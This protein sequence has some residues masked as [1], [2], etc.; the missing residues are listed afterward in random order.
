MKVIEGENNTHQSNTQSFLFIYI[1]LFFCSPPNIFKFNEHLI[2]KLSKCDFWN[3]IDMIMKIHEIWSYCRM[4]RTN[5]LNLWYS[6]IVLVLNLKGKNWVEN[7]RFHYFICPKEP[8]K[9]SRKWSP[10]LLHFRSYQC[11][12]FWIRPISCTGSKTVSH[13]WAA[14]DKVNATGILHIWHRTFES[15]KLWLKSIKFKGFPT[16]DFICVGYITVVCTRHCH[17]QEIHKTPRG[18]SVC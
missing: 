15:I 11:P 10:N 7:N 8:I 13:V 1:Y 5:C 18:K 17:I 6:K 16:F 2:L 12:R 3:Y 4:N 9:T 14:S